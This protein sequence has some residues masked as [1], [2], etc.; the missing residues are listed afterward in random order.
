M[1]ER[2]FYNTRTHRLHIEGYCRESKLKPYDIKF[3]SSENEVLAY[4][5]RAVGMC[6]L[7]LRE[8]EKRMKK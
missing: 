1:N 2:Y 5:G 4:D 3:F 8:R 6:K 7:C